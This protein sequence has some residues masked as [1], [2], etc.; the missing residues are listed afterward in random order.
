MK[1]KV[2]PFLMRKGNKVASAA[3]EFEEGM[4]KGFHLVGF[5]ICDDPQKGLLVLFPANQVKKTSGENQTY[6]FLIPND[7]SRITE[8]ETAILDVYEKMTE[9]FNVPK[10]V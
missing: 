7:D 8:L 4:L 1:I 2:Q 5:T 10:G 6:F 9:P 3:I